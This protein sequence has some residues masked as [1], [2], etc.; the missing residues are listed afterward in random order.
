MNR[1]EAYPFEKMGG[2][3]AMKMH[4]MTCFKPTQDQRLLEALA[5]IAVEGHA[6]ERKR[7]RRPQSQK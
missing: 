3:F 2:D 6:G 1:F 4:L 5:R 7:Q